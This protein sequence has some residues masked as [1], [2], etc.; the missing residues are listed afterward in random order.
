MVIPSPPSS[1]SSPSRQKEQGRSRGGDRNELNLAVIP[2]FLWWLCFTSPLV[3]FLLVIFSGGKTTRQ[4]C[5]CFT[6]GASR[7][8]LVARV[9]KCL[10]C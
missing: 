4:G 2:P 10:S 7:V 6:D 9:P 5:C 3:S 1:F 8:F